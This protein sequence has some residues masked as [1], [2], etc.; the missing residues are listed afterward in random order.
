M[1]AF[2]ENFIERW[3]RRSD[4]LSNQNDDGFSD[5][6]SICRL[7]DKN[8]MR[9]QR[10]T[11]FKDDNE[12]V[13]DLRWHLRQNALDDITE[14]ESLIG[15]IHE[16]DRAFRFDKCP[17]LNTQEFFDLAS[18]SMKSPEPDDDA[19]GKDINTWILTS[20]HQVAQNNSVF[21]GGIDNGP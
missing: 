8:V 11:I 15:S 10:L 12:N 18:R 19:I 6:E 1:Q 3:K 2:T 14:P 16:D 21:V 20:A 13:I 7:N 5:R 4:S 9:R 17:R